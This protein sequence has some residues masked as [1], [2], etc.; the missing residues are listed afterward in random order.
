MD[1]K[2][3]KHTLDIRIVL[4]IILLLGF[5][6]LAVDSLCEYAG[7]LKT[8]SLIKG[9]FFIVVIFFYGWQTIVEY[10]LHKAKRKGEDK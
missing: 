6:W 10:K 9:I 4:Y 7:T 8:K 3:E 2:I 1:N 5:V